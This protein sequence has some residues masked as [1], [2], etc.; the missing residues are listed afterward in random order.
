MKSYDIYLIRHGQHEEA[1]SGKYIGHTD[2]ALS[3][4]GKRALI[5]KANEGYPYV[6]AVFSSPLKRA[7][8]SCNI[9][10]PGKKPIIIEELAECSFG[11]WE[12]KTPEDLQGNSLFER[13]IMGDHDAI[14][15]FGES[16][17]EFGKRIYQGFEK[18]VDG[19][20]KSGVSSVAIVTHQGVIG[21]ILSFFGLPVLPMHEWQIENGGGFW[22][23]MDPGTWSR[24]RKIEVFGEF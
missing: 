11:D 19:V 7:T 12:G 14:P 20:F 4:K 17:E 10:Y 8:E 21:A 22:L 16:S 24:C 13:W 5:K 15:P 23:K 1:Q 3:S 2:V 9:M 18:I 6:E